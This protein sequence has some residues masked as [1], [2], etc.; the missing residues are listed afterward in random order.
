MAVVKLMWLEPAL[1]SRTKM[2]VEFR[3]F[4][5]E[6]MNTLGLKTQHILTKHLTCNVTRY[7][8]Q[9]RLKAPEKKCRTLS[10]EIYLS[11]YQYH[12]E[13]MILRPLT[14]CFMCLLCA[15]YNLVFRKV[16]SCFVM[17]G[18]HS[19]HPANKQSRQ[20]ILLQY[21]LHLH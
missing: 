3:R 2:Q 8:L 4:W 12:S 1:L 5:V 19:V 7:K 21:V 14:N 18:G 16:L 20:Y 10:W 6:T 13:R 9:V 11:D 15:T 17:L